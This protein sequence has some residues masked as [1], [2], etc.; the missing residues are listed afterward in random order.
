MPATCLITG[1]TGFVGSHTGVTLSRRGMIVRALARDGSD[2]KLL[3]EAGIKIVRGD[4]G[5][6]AAVRGAMEGTEI[7][8]HCAAKVGDWGHVDEYRKVNVEGLRNL[9]EASKG[10]SLDRFVHMSTLGV[11]AARHHHGTDESVPPPEHHVDG[12]TQSKVEAEQLAHRYEREFG[13]P[14]VI[15]RPGFVYGPRDR[16]VMPKLIT[17]LRT[18]TFRYLGGGERALNT[19][20]IDNLVDAVLLAIYRQDAVGQVYNL[21]DGELVSKRRFIEAIAEGMG[22][23]APRRSLPLWFARLLMKAM[24]FTHRKSPTPPRLTHARYKFLGLNLD[25]SIDKARSELGYQ[26]YVPF[27]DAIRATMAWYRQNMPDL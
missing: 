13:V 17:S 4:V 24:Y 22:I 14:V 10:Q 5:D 21:T 9:L 19:I 11:Y 23:A 3:E 1:A 27:E 2:T 6:P 8:V 12:Y 25:F 26:P 15:L 18:G 16:T 7:V 20:Y